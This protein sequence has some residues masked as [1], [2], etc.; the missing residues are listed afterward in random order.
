MPWTAKDA[1]KHHKGLSTQQ[2]KQWA[3]TAN[4]VLAS[5]KKKGG[6]DCDAIAIRTANGVVNNLEVNV[7]DIKL[8]FQNTPVYHV[9]HETYNG[10]NYLVVPVVMMVEGVHSGSHGPVLHLASELGKIPE[11]WNGMPV[12][13]N[14]PQKDGV[15]VSANSP[16]ILSSWAVGQVFNTRMEG[17]AL[18]AEAWIEES[19]IQSISPETLEKI[20]NGEIIEV[21]VGVFSEEEIADGEHNGEAYIAI[22]RNHRPNHLALLPD[23]TGACSVSDGCGI[24]TNQKGEKMSDAT[25]VINEENEQHVFKTLAERGITVNETGYYELASKAQTLLNTKDNG[26]ASFYLEEIFDK[27]IVYKVHQYDANGG[28]S[29]SFFKQSY[30]EN[31]AGELELTGEAVRVKREVSYPAVPQAN[32]KRVRTNLSINNSKEK[33]MSEK[34]TPCVKAA[35]D[36]LIANKVTA[37]QETDREWLENLSEEQLEKMNPVQVNTTKK[38]TK[39]DAVQVLSQLSQEEYLQTMPTAL[40]EQVQTGLRINAE[41]RNTLIEKI[42][43]NATS[44]SKEELGTIPTEMLEKLYLAVNKEEKASNDAAFFGFAAPQVN[45]GEKVEPLL[46]IM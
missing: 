32:E 4:S 17:D 1:E 34:C 12:T 14:H 25:L 37:Y 2:K 39:E 33:N 35:V 40:R 29:V 22:A 15:Y 11:S 42:T 23:A 9:R 8:Y 24:R 18:K 26:M 10:S 46:P 21:S 41:R 44:F 3:S 6:S 30:Q 19:R 43:V 45:E 20:N 7:D 28:R 13:I 16:E 38:I 27:E 5:C 31:A 36:N